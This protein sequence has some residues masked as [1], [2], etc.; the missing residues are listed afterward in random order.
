MQAAVALVIVAGD[1]K[2]A[3]RGQRDAERVHA[4]LHAGRPDDAPVGQHSIEVAAELVWAGKQLRAGIDALF[5]GAKDRS[6]HA[7][8]VV[9][10]DLQA[11][12][13][14]QL[15]RRR[16]GRA[17]AQSNTEREQ[18]QP[19]ETSFEVLHRSNLQD[20]RTRSGVQVMATVKGT[21][22][23]A[24]APRQARIELVGVKARSRAGPAEVPNAPVAGVL[25][26]RH[27]LTAE[28]TSEGTLLWRC[29]IL[30]K[31]D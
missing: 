1:Q 27:K 16:D 20:V 23:H 5:G 7:A 9:C 12:L 24:G 30:V 8:P 28:T 15:C 4:D 11:R 14:S 10:T 31:S 3:V 18:R 19:T 26:L 6:G 29:D 21:Q 13:R 17:E 22:R 2:L 25:G